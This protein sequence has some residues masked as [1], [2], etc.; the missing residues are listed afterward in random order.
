[1]SGKKKEKSKEKKRKEKVPNEKKETRVKCKRPYHV[2][3]AEVI[4][5]CD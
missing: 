4:T 5:E 1:M 3:Y 2:E